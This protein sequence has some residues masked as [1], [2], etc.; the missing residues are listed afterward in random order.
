VGYFDPSFTNKPTS[1]YKA[2]SI[3]GLYGRE[4]HCI[5]MFTRQAPLHDVYAWMWEFQKQLPGGVG[6]HWYIENQFYNDPFTTGLVEFNR[7]HKAHLYIMRDMRDKPDKY[8]RIVAMEPIYYLGEVAYNAAEI[9]NPDMI[10]G[11][12]QLKG[13]EPG[14]K[15]PDD[16]PDAAEGAWYYLQ[17]H[18]HSEDG[19]TGRTGRTTNRQRRSRRR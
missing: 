18:I 3:W 10:T 17:Q 19:S 6:I 9:H 13:I 1:D 5:K 14:Y 12:N 15:T 11:L 8:M 2:V 4:R 16:A 7:S